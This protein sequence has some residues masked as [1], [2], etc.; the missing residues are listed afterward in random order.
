MVSGANEEEQAEDEE[1]VML[2]SKQ[3]S[4]QNLNK[5]ASLTQDKLGQELMRL[6]ETERDIF[7]S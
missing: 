1:A 3:A 5:E 4:S 2:S 6:K 7:Q